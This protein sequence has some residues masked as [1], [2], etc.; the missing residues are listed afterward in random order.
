MVAMAMLSGNQIKS[1]DYKRVR[2]SIF[3]SQLSFHDLIISFHPQENDTVFNSFSATNVNMDVDGLWKVYFQNSLLIEGLSIHTPVVVVHKRLPKNEKTS[4]SLQTGEFYNAISHML[5]TLAI[6]TFELESGH[7]TFHLH[8]EDG[9]SPIT[10]N[11]LSLWIENFELSKDSEARNDKILFTDNI[12]VKLLNQSVY[13][14]DSI[15]SIHFDSLLLSTIDDSFLVHGFRIK[16]KKNEEVKANYYDLYVPRM[17]IQNID[18]TKAYNHH[19]LDIDRILFS[20][21]EVSI[22]NQKTSIR[23]KQPDLLLQ[24][25][26]IFGKLTI[27][28]LTLAHTNFS[29]NAYPIGVP[30]RFVLQDLTLSIF[31]INLDHSNTS[32]DFDHHYFKHLDLTLKS[33]SF[34][35]AERNHR[36]LV[37]NLHVS[38]KKLLF[39]AGKIKIHPIAND[40]EVST[41][42]EAEIENFTVEGFDPYQLVNDRQLFLKHLR[43]QKLNVKNTP[44]ARTTKAGANPIANLEDLFP[45]IQPFADKLKIDSLSIQNINLDIATKNGPLLVERASLHIELFDLDSNTHLL[46]ENIFQVKN[47]IAFLP[48]ATLPIEN[49]QI[50]I[51]SLYLNKDLQLLSTKSVRISKKERIGTV[52]IIGS[53]DELYFKGMK[54]R[55]LLYHQEFIFDTLIIKHPVLEIQETGVLS[56]KERKKSNISN[57]I[58][59]F[60]IGLIFIEDGEI[61]YSEGDLEIASINKLSLSLVNTALSKSHLLQNELLVKYDDFLLTFNN[62]YFS[63]PEFRHI[64]RVQACQFHLK[65]STGSI[66]GINLY[67]IVNEDTQTLF[68]VSIPTILF[69]GINDYNSYFN[70]KL[71]IS[72]LQIQQPSISIQAGSGNAG[73]PVRGFPILKS[74]MFLFGWD[75]LGIRDF[76]ITNGSLSFHKKNDQLKIKNLTLAV[77]DFE[78]H[79]GKEMVSDRFLFSKEVDVN[80]S[81]INY[82]NTRNN[83]SIRVDKIALNS[84]S[85]SL[86]LDNIMLSLSTANPVVGKIPWI[87]LTG[88]SFFE[89]TQNKKLV[90]DAITVNAPEVNLAIPKMNTNRKIEKFAQLNA[91]PFDTAQLA[92]ID[93]K[94]STI[95]N[96][97]ILGVKDSTL[98]VGNI[99]L[100]LTNFILHPDSIAKHNLPFHSEIFELTVSDVHYTFNPMN[101]IRIGLLD[102]RSKP[103]TVTIHSLS[104]VPLYDKLE[105]GKKLGEQASWMSLT[106]SKTQ[107]NNLDFEK[108]IGNKAIHAKSILIDDLTIDVFRDKR[109]PFPVNQVRK[110]PQQ[111]LR[112]LPF[113]VKIDSVSL[114]NGRVEYVEQS[115]KTDATGRIY[116]DTMSATI[117]NITNDSVQIHSTPIMKVAVETNLY[118]TGKTVA[119]FDF[120]LASPDYG[121]NY[122]TAIGAFDLLKLNEILEP[123]I[124]TKVREGKLNSLQQV[125]NANDNYAQGEMIFRYDDLKVGLINAINDPNPG[126]GKALASFFANTFIVRKKN[127]A[128]FVRKSDVF[129]VRNHSKSIF[130][131]LVK[132]TL[133][134]VVESIGARSNR[135]K[136]KEHKKEAKQQLKKKPKVPTAISE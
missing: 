47:F 126:L 30:D 6:S 118:G 10:I 74:S 77:K 16:A 46:P 1:I 88:F 125:V 2:F 81:H 130:D 39:S 83:D 58:S 52:G 102:Y 29:I 44:K 124:L 97:K 26:E 105:Y 59:E 109:L 134:G 49:Q 24:L 86:Q 42:N 20:G 90:L 107:I 131:F 64:L 21:G 103:S 108:L 43:V 38:T 93:I 70:K 115:A 61:T 8:G 73:Q 56:N 23:E 32:I 28:E 96:A 117:T 68:T 95:N 129:F 50:R 54:L 14:P 116:F 9:T 71:D 80:F 84:K 101:K 12:K 66:Q 89:F 55:Q 113:G 57:F 72:S 65:D 99:G 4:L 120:N 136:I 85:K 79:A 7:F 53:L 119:R 110:L 36:L 37:E 17:D 51:D 25:N 33:H 123:A 18:Y 69:K 112:E 22:D 27:E 62:L 11:N 31:E 45:F 92:A 19:E 106:N 98:S 75:S 82:R 40:S 60:E 135:K 133:S 5:R 3:S 48:A 132:S 128:P 76:N 111:N 87:E 13:L 122:S 94:N 41:L 91:Y 114:K 127:P 100:S 15:H 121:Y 63:T 78:V 34:E 104:I 67:P 35:M